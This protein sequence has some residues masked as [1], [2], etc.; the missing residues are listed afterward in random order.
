MR[1]VRAMARAKFTAMMAMIAGSVAGAGG[2]AVPEANKPGSSKGPQ[3]PAGMRVRLGFYG[4]DKLAG[5]GAFN[6][7]QGRKRTRQLGSRIRH[8]S[9][10]KPKKNSRASRKR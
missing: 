3:F 9:K 1:N 7:R 10:Q 8:T 5:H 6:Q 2:A 4:P